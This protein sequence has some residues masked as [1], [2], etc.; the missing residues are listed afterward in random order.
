MN[1]RSIIFVGR[2]KVHTIAN[3]KLATNLKKVAR[4]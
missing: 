4:L 1:F 3:Q 2:H